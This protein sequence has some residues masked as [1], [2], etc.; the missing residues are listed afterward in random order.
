MKLSVII[1]NYNV[2]YFLEQ[3]LYSVE[4]AIKGMDADVFVVDNVSVDGSCAMVKAKF[5]WVKLIENTENVGF[6]IAN[7]QAMRI[8]DAEYCLLLNP[9]TVVQ[10]DTFR[11]VVD[12]M[13]EHQDAGGLGV[14][15]VDGK[16]K[17][18]PESKRGLPT[19]SVS[20]YKIF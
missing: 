16:G 8:S 2:E 20:F 6:S 19:P 12:F 5:P 17:Y 7:N 9:D 1:V 11:Q 10:E 18:L 4:K 3:C 15:M 13:D 14:K